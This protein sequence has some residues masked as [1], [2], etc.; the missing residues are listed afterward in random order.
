LSSL[1]LFEW[2]SWQNLFVKIPW[3]HTTAAARE[4][5]DPREKNY[6]PREQSAGQ[7]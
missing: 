5:Q 4:R 2:R 6:S 3:R 7:E 1:L